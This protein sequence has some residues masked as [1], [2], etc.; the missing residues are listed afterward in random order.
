MEILHSDCRKTKEYG[1]FLAEIV[2]ILDRPH[3]IIKIMTKMMEQLMKIKSEFKE[4]LQ[5]SVSKVVNY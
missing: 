1:I 4:K 5:N 2:N 3:N